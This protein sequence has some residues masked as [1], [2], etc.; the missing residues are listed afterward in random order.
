MAIGGELGVTFAG[1]PLLCDQILHF[2]VIHFEDD[3]DDEVGH[4]LA[5]L[6]FFADR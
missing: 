3:L 4:A 5:L 1:W 2:G 6:F